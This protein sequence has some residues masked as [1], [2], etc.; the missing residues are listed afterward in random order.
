[1][2]ALQGSIVVSQPPSVVFAFLR[3]PKNNLKWE[4]GL[5]VSELT[6]PAP[7]TQGSTGRRVDKIMGRNEGTWKVTEFEQDK[8]IGMT[9]D[10]QKLN[11]WGRWR[12]AQEGAGTRIDY[13]FSAGAKGLL[14][15][16]MT[17]LFQPMMK[18]AVAKDYRKLKAALEN[19]AVK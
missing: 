5:E 17:F 1:M 3:D 19:G 7:M 2:P 4:T 16:V 10:S 8:V 6:S 11:G 12:L 15:K 9:F 13:E 18:G 14:G